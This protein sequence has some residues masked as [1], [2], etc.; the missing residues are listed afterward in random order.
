[1]HIKRKTIKNFW[2]VQRTGTKW[3]AVPSHNQRTAIPL[4]TAARDILK[5]VKNK[6]ELKMILNENKISIN[7]KVVK[8][9]NYPLSLFD[10]L[11]FPSAGKYYR[12]VMKN[13]RFDFTE[14]T[15]KEANCRIYRVIG[16]IQLGKNLT[17]VNF[18]C[19]RNILTNEKI[20]TGE[21]ALID[22]AKN[23]ITKII[24][25]KKDTEVIATAGKHTGKSGKVKE[26]VK[27]GDNLVALIKTK[28]G[29]IKANVKNIFAIG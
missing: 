5:V 14:I 16:K 25:L 21:F 10:V 2:P 15:E 11:S 7:G 8:E 1:M 20:K 22:L 28:E 24:E 9:T 3:M 4:I 23:K 29:E 19:G 18:E 27:E 26:I 12:I 6:K 17:Q 13:K